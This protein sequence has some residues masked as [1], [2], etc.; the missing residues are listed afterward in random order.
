MVLGIIYKITCKD[1]D[2]VYYGSTTDKLCR[3]KATHIQGV[4]RYDEGKSIRKCSSYQ[5]IKNNNYSLE[6]VEELVCDTKKDLLARERFYIENNSCVNKKLPVWS[7]EEEKESKKKW[8]KEYIKREDV[9]EKRKEQWNKY[10]NNRSEEQKEKKKE[11]DRVY[12]EKNR[13]EINTKK[14]EVY[15]KKH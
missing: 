14:R 1:T 9:K 10:Y 15:A 13:N 5:I 11:R 8:T 6:K 4:K 2:D 3:R 7:K 12:R